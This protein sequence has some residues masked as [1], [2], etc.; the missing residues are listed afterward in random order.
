MAEGCSL[1]V[2]EMDIVDSEGNEVSFLSVS[3]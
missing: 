1:D 3:E 2:S